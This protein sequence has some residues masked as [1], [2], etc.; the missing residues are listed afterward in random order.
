MAAS[1]APAPAVGLAVVPELQSIT[2]VR[3]DSLWRI[4]RRILGQG[5]RYTQIYEANPT[6]I[7]DPNRIFPGQVLVAPRSLSP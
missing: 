1:S 5:Q 2:V 4:S 6:Q 3:G 7:R